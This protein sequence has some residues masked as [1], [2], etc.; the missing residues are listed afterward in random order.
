VDYD[1]LFKMAAKFPTTV[2]RAVHKFI[3]DVNG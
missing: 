1:A 3:G 2:S